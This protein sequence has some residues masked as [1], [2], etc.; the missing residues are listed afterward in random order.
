M[1]VV[2]FAQRF[3][4]E[5]LEV[6][7]HEGQAVFVREDDHVFGALSTA[8]V[9]PGESEEE[10]HVLSGWGR[11][12]AFVDGCGAG[13]KCPD[14]ASLQGEWHQSDGAHDR[15]AASDPVGH[16]KN[17]QPSVLDGVGFQFAGNTAGGGAGDGHRL[18]GHV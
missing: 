18:A 4:D 12:S 10:R 6:F 2:L 11:A 15:G 7:A 9:V 5:L 13:E 14:I 16:G 17:L 1:A 3:H 8:G